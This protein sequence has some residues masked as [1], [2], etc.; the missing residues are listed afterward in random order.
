MSAQ[1]EQ[2]KT[3]GNDAFKVKNYR[4]A[5]IAYTQAIDIDPRSEAASALY[6]NR[7]ASYSALN[8]HKEA[9]ADAEACIALRPDWLKG[10]YR[11]A[12]ALEALG[13]LD[14]ALAAFDDALRTEPNNADVQE[15]LNNLRLAIKE[16]NEKAVPG[17]MRTPEEAKMIGNSLF[18]TGKYEK[19]IEFYTR[20]IDLSPGDTEEKASYFCNRAACHQQVHAYKSVISDCESALAINPNHAK[21][22]LRRAIALE[23]L[24]KWQRALDDY[25]RVNQLTP[26]LSNVSQGILRCQRAIRN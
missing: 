5:I 3:K 19:A 17:A 10:H 6:S 13:K 16:R 2:F 11:K 20:A 12:V 7:A 1:Q 4:E 18:K 21:A 23:G 9:L 14:D 25:N 26:G 22:L 15:R 8:Q 24:E